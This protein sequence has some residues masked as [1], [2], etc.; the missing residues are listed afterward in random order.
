MP[1]VSR[2]KA[3]K[4]IKD[5]TIQGKPLTPK[6]KRFFGA[7]AGV[8]KMK[9]MKEMKDGGGTSARQNIIEGMA[10]G[11]GVS[12]G[13]RSKP[14]SSRSNIMQGMQDGGGVDKAAELRAIAE[15]FRY[16]DQMGIDALRLGQASARRIHRKALG[17]AKPDRGGRGN[18]GALPDNTN[19][20]NVVRRETERAYRALISAKSAKS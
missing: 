18:P 10:I 19:Y 4:I 6:Q 3:R 20:A 7:A 12:D 14:D 2:E 17:S 9:E 16:R 8:A 1:K 15:V 5:G 13:Y 11:G